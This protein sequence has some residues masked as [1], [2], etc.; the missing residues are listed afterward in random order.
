M[1]PVHFVPAFLHACS[2]ITPQM[3]LETHAHQRGSS[4]TSSKLNNSPGFLL[5]ILPPANLKPF[6]LLR[7]RS[8]KRCC[9][10]TRWKNILLISSLP[11]SPPL[12][13]E[14][15]WCAETRAG[16]QLASG[17]PDTRQPAADMMSLET[18]GTFL[19]CH[20]HLSTALTPRRT[21]LG[22]RG[23]KKEP[24]LVDVGRRSRGLVDAWWEETRLR[25]LHGS[26]VFFNVPTFIGS[27]SCQQ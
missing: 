26:S 1:T 20:F 13:G 9:Q 23:G 21:V 4:D 17:K 6:C 11:P 14:E 8:N 27:R 24:L 7:H 3:L 15:S 5:P 12:V 18:A 19:W 10:L 2:L 22:R 16:S 25:W